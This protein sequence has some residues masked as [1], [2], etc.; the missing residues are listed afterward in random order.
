MSD[1][2]LVLAPWLTRAIGEVFAAVGLSPRA[3]Q[4][5]ASGLVDADMRGTP[6]HGTLLVPMYIERI[7]QGSVSLKEEASIVR[8]A[9][10][11]AVLDAHHALGQL[12][13]DQA[14]ALAIDK[15]R[16]YGIGAVTVRR[17]FHFGGAYRYARSAA[18]A[19]CIGIA[20]ANTRPPMPAP[21]AA[22]PV[23]GSNSIAI[24]V[25]VAGG[26]PLLFDMALSEAA[27]GKI[28]PA[29]QGGRPIP[30]T[31]AIDRDGCPNTGASAA[32]ADMLL[33]AAGHKGYGLDLLVDILTGALASG[34]FGSVRGRY[35]ATS[36][37]N[38]CAQF[39]LA[40]DIHTFGDPD[41]FAGRLA[42][43]TAQVTGSPTAPG[44]ERLLLPGQL[45]AERHAAATASG[46]AM[47]ARVLAALRESA[48]S[49]GVTLSDPC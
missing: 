1:R 30:A 33:P 22:A 46:I 5:V 14:M 42:T 20:A 44:G 37:P 28:R 45:E 38:D 9:E 12:T 36:V 49:V 35:A 8:D 17:A 24:G 40:L 19:G 13:G 6:S 26:E 11:I 39:F 31:W 21:G 47:D 2:T 4:S 23:V 18:A 32:P 3:A 41:A 16:S 25:P 34:G 15:A 10:A 27:L 29:E 48:A 7:R 43:L